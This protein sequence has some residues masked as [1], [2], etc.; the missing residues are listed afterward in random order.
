MLDMAQ[1]QA[2]SPLIQE[3]LLSGILGSP[4]V[5]TQSMSEGTS[6]MTSKAKSAAAGF[7]IGVGK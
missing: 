2:G 1:M 6:Q 7:K 4:T 5:L 3:S